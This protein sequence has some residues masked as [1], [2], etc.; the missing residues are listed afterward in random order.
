MRILCSMM[1]TS[2]VMA[3]FSSAAGCIGPELDAVIYE[4]SVHKEYFSSSV[5]L[6][7]DV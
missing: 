6:D 2:D 4:E 1:T 3:T 7:A 5:K